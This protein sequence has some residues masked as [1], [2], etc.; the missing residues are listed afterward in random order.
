MIQFK[1]RCMTHTADKI[2]KKDKNE[3][4]LN[5]W[6]LAS[7]LLFASLLASYTGEKIIAAILI[8]TIFIV[9]AIQ[10]DVSKIIKAIE[11]AKT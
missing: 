8:S 2:N 5:I 6:P 9:I 3:T 10:M 1:W 7:T 4:K 11:K